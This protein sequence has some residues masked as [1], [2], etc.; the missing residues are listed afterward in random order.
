MRVWGLKAAQANQK[1]VPCSSGVRRG[2]SSIMAAAEADPMPAEPAPP[3]LDADYVFYELT[4]SVCPTCRRVLDAAVLLRDDKVYLRKACPEHG[5]FE[6]LVYADAAAYVA[7]GRF[8]RPGTLPLQFSTAVE[9][10]CPH[11]CG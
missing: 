9:R 5:R 3:K 6:A 7:D 11:D 1:W 10:G 8:N 4:R 2:T